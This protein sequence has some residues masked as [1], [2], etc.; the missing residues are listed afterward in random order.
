MRIDA[1][2]IIPYRKPEGDRLDAHVFYRARALQA[3]LDWWET[4][5]FGFEVKIVSSWTDRSK[6][7]S[8]AESIIAGLRAVTTEYVIMSDGDVILSR[9]ELEG[10]L[11]TLARGAAWVVPQARVRRLTQAGTDA[12]Y[13]RSDFGIDTLLAMEAYAPHRAMP[14]GGLLMARAGTLRAVP[15]DPRF[16][17][18]GQE[19]EAW[20][21]AL[22]TLVG[23][24]HR[25]IATL[26]HLW[27]P[28][29]ARVGRSVGSPASKA[30]YARYVAAWRQPAKMRELLAEFKGEHG[31]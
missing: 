30:L 11:R 28:P 9:N 26:H 13:E 5:G 19:D 2:V 20:A 14:G 21:R 3:V 22:S 18:W 23:A 16:R 7:W 12:L 8:K 1:T 10:H 4:C 17:G 29:A 24:P 25:G 6:S 27:H 15:P 31:L